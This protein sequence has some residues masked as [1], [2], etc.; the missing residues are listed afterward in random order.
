MEIPSPE[1]AGHLPLSAAQRA[2]LDSR[3]SSIDH[4]RQNGVTWAALK[5]ELE[6]RYP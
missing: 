5:I 6:Q 2:E 4:D 3:L 1:E